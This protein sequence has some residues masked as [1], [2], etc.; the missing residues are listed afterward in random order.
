MHLNEAALELPGLRAINEQA[1]LAPAR[2]LG[3]DGSLSRQ[4]D[5]PVRDRVAQAA[6]AR[7]NYNRYLDECAEYVVSAVLK[8]RDVTG[9]IP[10]YHAS[11][12]RGDLGQ[13]GAQRRQHEGDH[14]HHQARRR[15]ASRRR[16]CRRRSSSPS[17]YSAA[18]SAALAREILA[19]P[20]A[21]QY[22]GAIGYHPY[23]YESA[24][25]S[26][27]NILAGPGSGTAR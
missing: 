18:Q 2:A 15:A 14:R 11:V 26:M 23:P 25:S 24:Y 8:W 3:A 20:D 6:F 10:R 13:P 9:E 21:R 7:A 27:A 12:Q 16:G 17:E 1:D 19:D 22:V 5:Q 4:R